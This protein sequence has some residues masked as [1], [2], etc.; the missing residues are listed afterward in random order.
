[1]EVLIKKNLDHEVALDLDLPEA[2]IRNL[3]IYLDHKCLL[4]EYS[5]TEEH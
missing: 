1:M 3:A 2:A 4:N 5:M